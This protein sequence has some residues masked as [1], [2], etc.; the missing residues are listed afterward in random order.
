[1]LHQANLIV[2]S[3]SRINDMV[4]EQEQMVMADQRMREQAGRPGPYDD[5]GSIYGDDM[6]THGFESKKRRGVR[7]EQ[8]NLDSSYC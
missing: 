5:E 1:M 4:Q 6:K 2:Q 3:I 7:S 8:L